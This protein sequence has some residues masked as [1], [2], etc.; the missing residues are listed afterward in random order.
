MEYG[1]LHEYS[2]K[3]QVVGNSKHPIYTIPHGESYN[4]QVTTM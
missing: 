2:P 4:A 1:N 3:P